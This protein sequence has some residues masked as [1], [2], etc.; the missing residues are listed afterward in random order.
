MEHVEQQDG[1]HAPAT[2]FQSRPSGGGNFTV[3]KGSRQ[4]RDWRP[5]CRY[6]PG[7]LAMRF[8]QSRS[9]M[10]LKEAVNSSVA[11]KPWNRQKAK[12]RA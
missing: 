5:L 12:T 7:L 3:L 9:S 1:Q 8:I 2:R 6:L 4:V 10:D 11:A